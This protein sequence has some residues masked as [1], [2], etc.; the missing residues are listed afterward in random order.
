MRNIYWASIA[1]TISVA[2]LSLKPSGHSKPPQAGARS[3]ASMPLQPSGSGTPLA[4]R[5]HA[6]ENYGK[7]PLSFEPTAGGTGHEAVRFLSH[8]KGY[9]LKLAGDRAVLSLRRPHIQRQ[10]AGGR[11]SPAR[12]RSQDSDPA[13]LE[14]KLIAANPAAA[15]S[16]AD[17]LPGKT[18][19]L[20]GNDPQ[21]WRTG[22]PNYAKVKF[23]AVYQGIDVVYYGNQQELEYDFVV[24]PGADPH[25]IKLGIRALDTASPSRA[26]LR[27]AENGDLVAP[28][29]GG[30]VQLHKP[31]AYQVDGAG[32]KRYVAA[33]YALGPRAVSFELGSYDRSRTLVIDPVVGYS[34]Y[35]G[36]S[37]NEN[38][39]SGGAI[40]VD[41]QGNAYVTGDTDSSDFPTKNPLHASHA[42][43]DDSDVFVSKLS[44]DGSKLVY[45]TYLGGTGGD[46]GYGI[47]VDLLGQAYIVGS[48]TSADF[49]VSP[50]AFQT[51]YKGTGKRLDGDAFVAKLSP[52]GTSLVYA[53]YLGGSSDDGAD[54]IAVD[55]SGFAYVAG[56]TS[57]GDFPVTAGAV[58]SLFGGSGQYGVGDA[59][60]AKLNAKGS[61]LVYST[62]LGGSNDDY[63]NSM[64]IDGLGDA[65]VAGGSASVNFPVTPGAYQTA[66][67]PIF[68]GFVAKLNAAGTKLIYSTYLSGSP[69]NDASIALALDGFG[70]AYVAGDTLSTNFPVSAEAFQK[71]YHGTGPLGTGDAFVTKLNTTGSKL[72]YSTYLGGSGDDLI[73][74]LT[75]DFLGRVY[76][77]GWTNSTDF[78]V[79]PGA[80][81]TVFGGSGPNQQ[82]DALLTVL[83][84]EASALLYSTYFGGSG[85]DG[86]YGIARDLAG[87]IYITGHTNSANYYVTPGAFQTIYG[88]DGPAPEKTGDAFVTRFNRDLF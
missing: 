67:V 38:D 57:S 42:A 73:D 66:F 86:A 7:L 80:F 70:N 52:S 14:M 49:P 68:D 51:T 13:L 43:G 84:T 63:V 39:E 83:N 16:A 20:I 28:I 72:L 12:V 31:V 77:T 74:G 64:A 78:P 48:T 87:N 55:L 22:I 45:S 60:V 29:G 3:Q 88:G 6:A 71:V 10:K 62:F 11:I 19:Y 65:V 15:A 36:G 27:I 18:N 37:L 23:Q 81:Q 79:T 40:A 46:Q 21:H 56:W 85:D 41:F 75:V 34:T 54:A 61:T 47:A 53:T 35:L 59:F 2:A 44:A 4:A 50:G 32:S 58:Q 26:P 30:E 17:A 5:K 33:S 24:G 25:A 1:L 82:G 76:L 9:T 8:G 69:A